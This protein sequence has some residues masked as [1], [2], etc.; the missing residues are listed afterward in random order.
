[1]GGAVAT[2]PSA[3]DAPSASNTPVA[4]DILD[5][6]GPLRAF[7]TRQVRLHEGYADL[8]RREVLPDEI[9]DQVVI[10]ALQVGT[11]PAGEAAFPWLRGLARR[12]IDGALA[13]AREQDAMLDE[14]DMNSALAPDP[15]ADDGA[16]GRPQTLISESIDPSTAV[17]PEDDVLAAEL[18]VHLDRALS[19]LPENER[20]A[21][22]LQWRDGRD[23]DDVARIEGVAVPEARRRLADAERALRERLQA[24][25]GAAQLPD[26][27]TIL[28]AL[29]R[30]SLT[31]EH[32]QRVS[33][34]FTTRSGAD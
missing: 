6:L 31:E 8:S 12:A 3:R 4:R 25:Y 11:R 2:E 22:L 33:T 30:T 9:I 14:S 27:E 28:Q 24:S 7:V 23:I 34:Q 18:R 26:A 16:V 5:N 29:E 19:E 15:I 21:L 20:E 10:E 32:I 17:S 1:M 13:E